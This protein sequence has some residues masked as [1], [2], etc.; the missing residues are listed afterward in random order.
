MIKD[1]NQNG[2][3]LLCCSNGLGHCRRQYI[4]ALEFQKQEYKVT[5]FGPLKKIEKLETI[6]GKKII[7]K[8]DFNT[9]SLSEISKGTLFKSWPNEV[10]NKKKY[11][12]VISDNLLEILLFRPD[13]Y[14]MGSFFWHYAL[15][16]YEKNNKLNFDLFNNLI[17]QVN[18]II[19]SANFLTPDYIKDL[20]NYKGIGLHGIKNNL[21][22][23]RKEDLLI[24]CGKGGNC[25]NQ[26]RL[27]VR[28]IA[29]INKTKFKNIWVEPSLYESSLPN[30][31][32]PANYS[33]DMYSRVLL[34]ICRPG[35]GTITECIQHEIFTLLFYE[36]NNEMK[37]IDK[38]ISEFNIG[39]SCK[40]II[41]LFDKLSY[42]ENNQEKLE[43]KF[44]NK[45]LPQISGAEDVISE[46]K[47]N[48]GNF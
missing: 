27:I 39:F 40:D 25:E 10:I 3:A 16:E 9:P 4:Q 48:L 14:L 32:K 13:A 19:F 5:L 45:D 7:I 42:F 21:K 34:A 29:K 37:F 35:I 20:C 6:Y 22:K 28:K 38:R 41:E 18:P 26:Y 33:S 11:K 43:N 12:I 15:P 36:N 31:M 23:N 2:I 17:K 46:L 47:S 30:F 1:K 44:S 8:K 24:S